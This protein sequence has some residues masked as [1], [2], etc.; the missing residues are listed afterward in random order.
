MAREHAFN[1]SKYYPGIGTTMGIT[2][3]MFLMVSTANLDTGKHNTSWHVFCAGN[4]FIWSILSVWW[5][6]VQSVILY[7]KAKA[8]NPIS[9]YIKVAFSLLIL[10][11]AF[12]DSKA[13]E[14]MFQ[15]RLHSHLSN[16]LEYTIAFSL[17]FFFLI[18]AY[19]LRKFKMAYVEKK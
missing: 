4:F 19:D 17:L 15:N 3:S 13:N 10:F 9:M 12:L 16:I 2:G 7:T 8:G 5:Y 1:I 18:I 6:T 11:Q 14:H